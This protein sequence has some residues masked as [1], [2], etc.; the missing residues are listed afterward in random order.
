MSPGAG[1]TESRNARVG[2]DTGKHEL[3][4]MQR[5]NF[6]DF[7]LGQSPSVN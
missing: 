5:F 1:F 3:P 7:H 4:D 6:C 2:A